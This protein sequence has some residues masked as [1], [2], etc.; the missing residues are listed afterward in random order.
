MLQLFHSKKEH[1]ILS[2]LSFILLY[3]TSLLTYFIKLPSL[4]SYIANIYI[5]ITAN[6]KQKLFNLNCEARHI[7]IMYIYSV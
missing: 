6:I 1:L 3:C 7:L 2:K 4:N 5:L